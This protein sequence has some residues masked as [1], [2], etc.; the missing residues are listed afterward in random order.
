M[1]SRALVAAALLS[2]LAVSRA[3][4]VELVEQGPVGV[5]TA[6]AQ[7]ADADTPAAAYYNPATLAWQRGLTVSAGADLVLRNG[8]TTSAGG[9]T[10]DDTVFATPIVFVGQRIG[11]RFAVGLG[12]YEPFAWQSSYPPNWSGNT[13]GSALSLHAY[14]VNPSV[15]IRFARW[16]AIGFGIDII[17]TT[18]SYEVLAFSVGARGTGVGGNAG[19]FVRIVPRW[20]DAAFSYRSAVDVELPAMGTHTTLSLPHTFSWG[21]ASHPLAGLTVTVDVR[22]VLWQDLRTMRW[23]QP[24]G[25]SDALLLNWQNSVGVRAGAQYR[26]WRERLVARV[27][28]GWEQS[29]VAPAMTSPVVAVGDRGLIGGGVGGRWRWLAIDAGYLATIGS[30]FTGAT[31]NFVARYRFVSH[32]ASVALTLRLPEWPWHARV[33]DP[34]Y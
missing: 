16:L 30:E 8:V 19:V 27:G 28:G 21:L 17:P 32:T 1:G 4:A 26:F 34:S 9:E 20:L 14:D 33:T 5:A 13:N 15:A 24:D 10:R 31:N 18:F 23:T 25:T 22:Y 2:T 29:P 12:V 7:T 11:N 6:G 3:R